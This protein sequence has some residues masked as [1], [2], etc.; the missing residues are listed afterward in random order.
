MKNFPHW[1]L[2]KTAVLVLTAVLFLSGGCTCIMDY[3]G[4]RNIPL[5]ELQAEYANAESEFV[6][7]N[8]MMVHLRDEGAGPV[9]V[10]LHGVLASLHTWDDWVPTL[11]R[12]YRVIRLDLPSFGLTGTSSD[13]AGAFDPELVLDTILKV[14]ADRGVTRATF[15]GS[16]FGGYLCWRLAA[17]HP[18]LVERMVLI[19]AVSFPQQWTWLI[20]APT[21][22]PLRQLAPAIT[23]R[24]TVA[25]GL[26]QAY[27]DDGRIAPG[28]I[29]RYHRLLLRPGNRDSMIKVLD[30]IKSLARP[31]D[32]DPEAGLVGLRQPLMTMWGKKDKWVPFDPVGRRWQETYPDAVHVVYPDVGH[33][34]MEEIP[35]RSLMDL[36]AFL[37]A[38]DLEPGRAR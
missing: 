29:R 35:A 26:H 32:A 19:D 7:V 11:A 1:L 6:T 10:L 4:L 5:P 18:H 34:P 14:L 3:H 20:K 16:S 28:T 8:G 15:I 17:E 25:I 27:G 38:T 13:A 9:L 30:W 37:K 33:M 36:M 2:R 31:L 24:Y 12:N 23:P 22:F 21:W